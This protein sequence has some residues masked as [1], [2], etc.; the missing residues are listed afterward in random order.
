MFNIIL[1]CLD[2]LFALGFI[3]HDRYVEH[4]LRV[5]MHRR[6]SLARIFCG[7]LF[8]RLSRHGHMRHYLFFLLCCNDVKC[9]FKYMLLGLIGTFKT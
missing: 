6:F 9:G 4:Q 1:L 8:I 5:E 3:F 2:G 7:L